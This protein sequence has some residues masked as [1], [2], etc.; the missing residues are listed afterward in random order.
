[1]REAMKGSG[2]IVPSQGLGDEI[3]IVL[4]REAEQTARI[5]AEPKATMT[6]LIHYNRTTRKYA[7]MF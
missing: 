6:I 4:H 3:P 7:K 2:D 5:G 1:M